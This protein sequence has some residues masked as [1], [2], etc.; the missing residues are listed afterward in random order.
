MDEAEQ[1]C[2]RIILLNKGEIVKDTNIQH[3]MGENPS[4][5]LT[6]I[7]LKYTEVH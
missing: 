2:N 1:I 7:F 5:S 3:L 6:E 4:K